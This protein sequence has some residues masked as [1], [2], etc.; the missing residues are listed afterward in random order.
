MDELLCDQQAVGDDSLFF[1]DRLEFCLK[2]EIMV[3]A[4]LLCNNVFSVVIAGHLCELIVSFLPIAN[5]II[6]AAPPNIRSALKKIWSMDQAYTST[7]L[8]SH[9]IGSTGAKVVAF[10]MSLSTTSCN[11]TM[12]TN[13]NL[14]YNL[15][16]DTGAYAIATAIDEN[17]RLRHLQLAG[18]Q[19]G[20]IGATAI[21]T[22]IT[23]NFTLV[24]LDLRNNWIGDN[25]A[26]VLATAIRGNGTLKIL[27]ISENGITNAGVTPLCRSISG[28]N[29][30]C[31]LI[32]AG[33]LIGDEGLQ[34]LIQTVSN[35]I[36]HRESFFVHS[37]R[38]SMTLLDLRHNINITLKGTRIIL[39]DRH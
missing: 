38:I 37:P 12:L 39:T 7:A 33:N 1:E 14:G 15:I 8:N 24:T 17:C 18:N 22:A 31:Q 34:L 26:C 30:L 36:F 23:G 10:A 6:T 13:L 16:G 21:A 9:Y 3:T 29:T 27:D 4:T 25:G 32:L 5:S 35:N 19:I 20:I 28:N 11:I 2:Y